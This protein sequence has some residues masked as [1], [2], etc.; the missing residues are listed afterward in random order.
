M[1]DHRAVGSVALV[2]DDSRVFRACTAELLRKR[3]FEVYEVATGTE[4]LDA[5]RLRRPEL[6]V[7]DAL[8]PVLSGFDVLG[9]LR[10][11]LPDYQPTVFLVTGVYKGHRWQGESRQRYG[12]HEYL[13]KPIED[14]TLLAA[15]DRHFPSISGPHG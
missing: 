15:V 14:A 4:A 10:E 11:E 8:M 7:L 9:K 6:L 12:V 3:G 2:A 13:E 1:D 5:A